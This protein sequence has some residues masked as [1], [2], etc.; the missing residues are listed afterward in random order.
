MELIGNR[1]KALRNST[2]L[3]QQAFAEIAGS[4]QSSINRFENN[5]SEPPY[6]VLTWYCDYFDVSADFLLCRTDKPQGKLYQYEPEDM[7]K[8]MQNKEEWQQF[9]E[10]CF[11]PNS[12]LN[13]KLKQAILN[14]SGGE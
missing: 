4:T 2:G 12:P 13:E 10:A 3:S 6:R 5:Q 11:E 1:L 14:M 9:I 8:R 7:K